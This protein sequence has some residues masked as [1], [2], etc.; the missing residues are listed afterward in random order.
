VNGCDHNTAIQRVLAQIDGASAGGVCGAPPD[1]QILF[2]SRADSLD[3]RRVLESKYQAMGRPLTSTYVDLEGSAIWIQEYERYRVNSCDHATAEAKVFSQIDGGPVPPTCFV[4]CTLLVSPARVDVFDPATSGTFEVRPSQAGC[5]LG[6]TASSDASWLT[7][8]SSFTTGT[9]FTTVPYS[10]GQNVGGSRSAKIH[11]AWSGGSADFVVNQGGTPYQGSFTLTDPFRG[12]GATSECWFRSLST[13]CNFT[14]T[15]NLPGS[16]NYTYTWT[17]TYINGTQKTV[18]LTT[19][20]TPNFSFSDTCGTTDATAEGSPA[21]L[22]VTLTI[23]DSAGNTISLT[24]GQGNQPA[25]VVRRFT[26]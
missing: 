5:N 23:T 26:C 21:D 25:L 10:V 1:G 6:W 3:M 24:S 14:A 15:A 22:N 2:P 9:G 17:A 11:V 18:A 7:I 16:G 19:S 12:P 20:A 13:P 4:A 8:P